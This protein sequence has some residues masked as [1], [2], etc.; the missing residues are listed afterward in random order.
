VGKGEVRGGRKLASAKTKKHEKETWDIAFYADGEQVP[1]DAFMRS[2]PSKP[3]RQLVVWIL[4]VAAFPPYRF[5]ASTMFQPMSQEGAVDMSGFHET[6]DEHDGQLYRLLCII[7]RHAATKGC[8]N[9]VLAIIDGINKPVRTKV[10]DA[11]YARIK[12]L[13]EDYRASNPRKVRRPLGLPGWLQ[14]KA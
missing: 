11:D 4:A 7:D 5:P 1:A 3:R 10:P 2:I 14:P 9:P 8:P 6:R 13:G 12:R